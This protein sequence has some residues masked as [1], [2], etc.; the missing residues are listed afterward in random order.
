MLEIY[1]L[2]TDFVFNPLLIKFVLSL[3]KV[4]LKC[5]KREYITPSFRK[6]SFIKSIT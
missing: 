5:R 1:N 4:D 6:N 2:P 3:R